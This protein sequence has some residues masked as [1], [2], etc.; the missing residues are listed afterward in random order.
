M[1]AMHARRQSPCEEEDAYTRVPSAL[2]PVGHATALQFLTGKTVGLAY[3]PHGASYAVITAAAKRV[4]GVLEGMLH[5]RE[6]SLS[7]T[8]ASI[9]NVVLRLRG[10][11]GGFGQALKAKGK[12]SSQKTTSF[13]AC[14]NLQGQR[15]RH[16][17]QLEAMKKW[18][19]GED[20]ADD[21]TLLASGGMLSHN[22]VHKQKLKNARLLEKYSK[23]TTAEEAAKRK[24]DETEQYV[25]SGMAS[26]SSAALSLSD[27]AKDAVLRGAR[28]RKGDMTCPEAHPLVILTVG[29]KG[30]NTTGF[31]F[32]ICDECDEE[33]KGSVYRCGTCDYD[34]CDGCRSL[35][36]APTAA[37]Q[38]EEPKKKRAKKPTAFDHGLDDSS[39]D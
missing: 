15:I 18:A 9:I 22:D 16:Q 11:K 27:D 3:L 38:K 23:D 26:L 14:K 6:A 8:S 1:I 30:D 34:I 7:V 10:G 33:I 17:R 25:R 13:D 4:Y 31:D 35:S 21:Q 36:N 19:Q 12:H 2:Q 20:D 24:R 5:F 39:E 28:K 29:R 37:P 32:N